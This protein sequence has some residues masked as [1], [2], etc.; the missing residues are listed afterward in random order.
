M[1]HN[2][3]MQSTFIVMGPTLVMGPTPKWLFRKNGEFLK[4]N[5]GEFNQYIG[6]F[7]ELSQII[8]PFLG[9]QPF[10]LVWLFLSV[11]ALLVYQKWGKCG[12][13]FQKLASVLRIFSA[14]PGVI[15]CKNPCMYRWRKVITMQCRDRHLIRIESS[16]R[17][18]SVL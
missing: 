2:N 13:F 17:H 11:N 3:A 9:A 4:N 10:F 16:E 8:S 15:F 12:D 1:E 6:T 14:H 7:W 18:F 5:Y